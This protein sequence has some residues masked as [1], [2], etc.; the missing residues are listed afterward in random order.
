MLEKENELILEIFRTPLVAL[1]VIGQNVFGDYFM[2][3][4]MSRFLPYLSSRL[5]IP[6]STNRVSPCIVK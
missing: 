4:F 3:T 6:L 2:E 5:L 1:E